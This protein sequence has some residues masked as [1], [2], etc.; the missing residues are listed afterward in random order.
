VRRAVFVHEEQVGPARFG[1]GHR[2]HRAS[3]GHNRIASG[4]DF[5]TLWEMLSW[6]ERHR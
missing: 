3:F 2:R 6:R 1:F 4:Y 5:C